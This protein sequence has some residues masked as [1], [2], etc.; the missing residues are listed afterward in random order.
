MK[1]T[2][3]HLEKYGYT[4]DC[5]GCKHKR[6]GMRD[7]RPHSEACRKRIEEA[8]EEDEEGREQKRRNEERINWKIVEGLEES[9]KEKRE[10]PKPK[11]PRGCRAYCAEPEYS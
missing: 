9:G 7:V 4:D 6:A 2:G 3:T 10:A 11:C 5:E 8:M 1:I